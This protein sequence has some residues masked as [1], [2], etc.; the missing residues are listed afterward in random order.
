MVIRHS[1]IVDRTTQNEEDKTEKKP[2]PCGYSHRSEKDD[3]NPLY[4]S[5][6]NTHVQMDLAPTSHLKHNLCQTEERETARTTIKEIPTR[7]GNG[8]EGLWTGKG[9]NM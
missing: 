2:R 5:E 6:L 3:S 9:G 7:E 4:N 8:I 1:T